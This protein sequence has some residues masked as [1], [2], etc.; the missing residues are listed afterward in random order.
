MRTAPILAIL[1]LSVSAPALADDDTKE[2][3]GTPKTRGSEVIEIE[4]APPPP[5]VKAK[6]KKRYLARGELDNIFLR[7]APPYSDDAITSD[8]WSVA[9]MLLDISDKGKVT[10]VKFLK[11]PGH[12][13]ESIAVEQALKLKFEPAKDDDDKPV[14]SYIVFP[15]EWPS[16]WWLVIRTG[17]ATGIPDTSHI[18]CRGSGPLNMGSVH[19]TYRDCDPPEWEKA[20]T[21][22]WLTEPPEK[23]E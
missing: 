18:P 4:G 9:W 14:R 20:N 5:K 2:D 17:L 7:P 15:I 19:P 23:K 21:E 22:P 3:D 6:P 1:A 16:Y 10:R 12:D 13:L 11:Y 8:T